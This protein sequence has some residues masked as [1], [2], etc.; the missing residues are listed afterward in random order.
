MKE[1]NFEKKIVPIEISTKEELRAV[2]EQAGIDLLLWEKDS[3]KGLDDLFKEIEDKECSLMWRGN[4]IVRMLRSIRSHVFFTTAD[5]VQL[6]LV[7]QYQ[8]FT[9]DRR[10]RERFHP[11]AVGEKMKGDTLE[12]E[13]KRAM[14][15]ELAVTIDDAQATALE[16]VDIESPSKSYPGIITKK[17]IAQY[18]VTLSPE[19]YNENGYVEKQDNKVTVFKWARL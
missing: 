6:E 2:L 15:E 7:E 14:Y 18:E 8:L 10:I 11:A 19:Q 3:A 13:L 16:T 4:E 17:E 9:K 5:G 1:N 12:A